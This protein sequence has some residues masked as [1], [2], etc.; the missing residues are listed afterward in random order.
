MADKI[1]VSAETM[2]D[3]ENE[4]EDDSGSIE[5][6]TLLNGSIVGHL[7][8]TDRKWW[9]TSGSAEIRRENAPMGTCYLL[10]KSVSKQKV[11]EANAAPAATIQRST[12]R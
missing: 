5:E 10:W 9:T 4:S 6:R 8:T 12:H 11:T 3:N 7:Y 2:L 1:K